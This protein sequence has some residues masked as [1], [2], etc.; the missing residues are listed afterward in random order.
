MVPNEHKLVAWTAKGLVV[1]VIACI[2]F[3][4]KFD[5]TATETALLS[6]ILTV[7]SILATC[8]VSHAYSVSSKNKAIEEVKKFHQENL[9]MYAL[10]AAEK[11]TNL[12]NELN[13]LSLYIREELD[14]EYD[15]PRQ[16]LHA[17]V[18]RMESAVH[19]LYTLKSV[20]DTALS[21]WEGV[22]GE[23]IHEQRQALNEQRQAMLE[24]QEAVAELT[25]KIDEFFTAQNENI[26]GDFGEQADTIMTEVNSI[27]QEMGFL[28]GSLSGRSFKKTS[29]KRP[30]RRDVNCKC[31]MCDDD[32]QY[33]QRPKKKS[34][35]GL[36][37]DNC[38]AKLVSR[39]DEDGDEFK[40]EL[41]EDRME[42]VACPWCNTAIQIAL[43]NCPGS[44]DSSSCDQCDGEFL[45]SRTVDELRI[46]CVGNIPE[47]TVEQFV[48]DVRAAL[49]D[50][51]WPVRIHVDIANKLGLKPRIVHAAIQKLMDQG[52]V[53]YQ[54]NGKLYVRDSETTSAAS[55][56]G[57]GDFH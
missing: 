27:R 2:F 41:R 16:S 8:L 25:D 56:N 24:N 52:V 43:D 40:I 50:Q 19:M 46:K 3:I 33:Q 5:M 49:P 17:K 32:L 55:E 21:D 1:G 28:L 31:P 48:D 12:S 34:S 37:C 22:I 42:H 29:K 18:E 14:S 47:K 7:F 13:R 15:S 53:K 45:V 10:K 9:R 30:A 26:A 6:I 35:K 57:G 44:S 4:L 51:P 20:N 38:G 39:F 36:A 11:V 23:E 54:F